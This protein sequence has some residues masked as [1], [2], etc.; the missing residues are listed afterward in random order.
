MFIT[1]Y[2]DCFLFSENKQKHYCSALAFHSYFCIQVLHCFENSC[3]FS[4]IIENSR[5]PHCLYSLSLT[6]AAFVCISDNG[7]VYVPYPS[8]FSALICSGFKVFHPTVSS[9]P[10]LCQSNILLSHFPQLREWDRL[11][12][13]EMTDRV[14]A[15]ATSI[16]T[17]IERRKWLGFWRKLQETKDSEK[18]RRGGK[19]ANYIYHGMVFLVATILYQSGPGYLSLCHILLLFYSYLCIIVEGSWW[20]HWDEWHHPIRDRETKRERER[21]GKSFPFL[22]QI[23]AHNDWNK[24]TDSWR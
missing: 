11:S 3:P 10:Q 17:T 13:R 9:P 12:K 21:E 2:N 6:K 19:K 14:A 16:Q 22:W 20:Q 18:E 1:S 23:A 7:N 4:L 24:Y 15:L 5:K 8:P